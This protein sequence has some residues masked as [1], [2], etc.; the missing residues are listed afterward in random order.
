[1]TE[2]ELWDDLNYPLTE[3]NGLMAFTY[4]NLVAI[5]ELRERLKDYEDLEEQGKLIKLP[6]KLGDTVYE[7]VEGFVEPCT[8]QTIFIADYTDKKGKVSY[9]AEIN[10]D[11]EDCPYT[12]SEIFLTDIGKTVFLSEPE[13]EQALKERRDKQ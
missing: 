12:S 5:G 2:E 6:F 10:Y 11:R 8:V 3:I 4:R 1:M 13:A 7:L 9:M